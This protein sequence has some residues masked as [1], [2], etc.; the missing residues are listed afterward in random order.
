MAASLR[1]QRVIQRLAA[2]S[3]STPR[4][5]L[6][7][8]RK[9]LSGPCIICQHQLSNAAATRSR[10]PLQ[11]RAFTT[12]VRNLN[13][14]SNSDNFSE[15]PNAPNTTTYYTIF[16]Q[17]LPTGPPPSS[18]FAVDVALLR[19]EFLQLQNT[20]HPDKYP[21]GPTKQAAESLS[22]TINEAYR[23]LADPLLRAQYILREFHGID[24]TA[25]DGAGSHPLDPE[26]L[27]E[28]MD[29]QETIEE[30]GEGPEAEAQI[31]DMKKENDER[32]RGCVEALGNAFDEGN[33]EA[34]TGE[35]VRLKF[36]VSVAEGLKEWEPGMG[37][38]RL[39][40]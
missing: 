19:R 33:V 40:H 34:A 7:A 26:L 16:P 29:V 22:A 37:G 6:T 12:T 28:V 15:I 1:S 5:F 2:S 14:D 13:P 35:C 32:L 21:P 3:R 30:V 25:E 10:S 11:H 9:T 38:I 27:M 20:I 4:S 39:V 8:N 36:W 17:T 24:V 31:A 23:T 18:P